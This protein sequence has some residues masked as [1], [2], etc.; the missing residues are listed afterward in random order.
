MTLSDSIFDLAI[1]GGGPAALAEL[2]AVR[3]SSARIVVLSD[4]F[5]GCMEIMGDQPLQSYLPE[6]AIEGAP[7]KLQEFLSSK[8]SN[9]PT[10]KE[11]TRYIRACFEAI[12]VPKIEC[13]VIDLKPHDPFEVVFEDGRGIHSLRAEKVVL[14]TGLRSRAPDRRIPASAWTTCF[15]AYEAI[16]NHCLE[17]FEGKYVGVVGTGNTAYQLALSLVRVAKE[18]TLLVNRY[19]GFFPLESSDGFALRA[20]SFPAMELI[21][22]SVDPASSIGRLNCNSTAFAPL[23]LHAYETIGYHPETDH[24]FARIPASLNGQPILSMSTS[25]AVAMGRLNAGS[26]DAY[27]WQR[28]MSETTMISAIGVTGNTPV[29]ALP[30]LVDETTGFVRHLNGETEVPGLYVSGSLAGYPS[31]NKMVLSCHQRASQS[32]ATVAF[33]S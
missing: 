7:F 12:A 21:R 28:P 30:G 1:I 18:I 8:T 31:V 4:K 29:H 16:S 20:P 14:A 25:A 13:R 19:I 5:G 3:K 26:D 27:V 22:K 32:A 15:Q 6:L 9:S 2:L 10:G 24:V 17:R 33:S 11:Y 23:Y